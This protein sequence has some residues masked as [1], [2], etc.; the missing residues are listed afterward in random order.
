MLLRNSE[1]VNFLMRI[2][3]RDEAFINTEI[4]IQKHTID[5]HFH[6]SQRMWREIKSR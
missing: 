1:Y 2:T 4:Y 5:F 3:N 6:F